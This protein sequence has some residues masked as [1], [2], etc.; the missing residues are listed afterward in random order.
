MYLNYNRTFCL[1]AVETLIERRKTHRVLR[2][3][4]FVGA[5]LLCPIKM[6]LGLY[7]LTFI[8]DSNSTQSIYQSDSTKLHEELEIYRVVTLNVVK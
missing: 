8:S 7:G 5:V 6:T 1:Q 3:L 4:I 2:R